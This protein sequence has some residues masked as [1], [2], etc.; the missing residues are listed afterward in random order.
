M[1]R[2][3]GAES[4]TTIKREIGAISGQGRVL[5]AACTA[6]QSAYEDKALGH[7]CFT[8]A[9]LRGLRGEAR[10]QNGEV[11]AHSLYE[12]IDR[13]VANPSQQPVFYGETTRR[14]V[15]VHYPEGDPPSAKKEAP[16]RGPKAKG[17]S[18]SRTGTWVMLGDHY[19][20][21]D[22]VRHGADNKV[23][24]KVTTANG[25]EAAVFAALR[26]RRYGGN[27]SLP[28]AANHDAHVVRVENVESES[29]GDQQTWILALAADDRSLGG[30]IEITYVISGKSYTP[31]ALAKLRA[32]RILLNDPAP[33]PKRP[34][35][36]YSP[37][38]DLGMIDGSGDYPV[39]ECVVRSVY[40][41]HGG[42][43]NWKTFAKLKAIFA[44]KAAGV[45]EHVL[46]LTVG[47]ARGEQVAIKFRGQRKDG[48]NGGVI[49]IDGACP[50]GS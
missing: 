28:F 15:L 25:H 41:S 23:E 32:G 49:E 8:H 14:I 50:L 20:L 45:V 35:E 46:E 19:F 42:D 12:F 43:P 30:G 37:D 27:P 1:A 3:D 39:K 36:F 4:L 2:G 38:Q 18:P 33:Q 29:A 9:L 7:G 5:V 22:S 21:A 13:E 40:A 48:S 16:K 6:A 24:L 31:L 34:R 47:P 44:L 26:G 11:T 10:S 17:K